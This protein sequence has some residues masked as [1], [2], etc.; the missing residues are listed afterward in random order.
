[1]VAAS[2]IGAT[3]Q[4]REDRALAAWRLLTVEVG[5]VRSYDG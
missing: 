5:A 4:E 3:R 1:M 2:V